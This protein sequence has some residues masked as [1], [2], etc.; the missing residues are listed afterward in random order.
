MIVVTGGAGFIG[1]NIVHAL[2][3]RGVTDMLIVDNL[4]SSYKFLNINALRYSD[5]MHKDEFL[6]VLK[7]ARSGITA[8]IHQGACSDT[9]QTDNEYLMRN[10]YLYSKEVL[11]ACN[12][13][14]IPLI[15]A[16]SAAV[17]G[18]AIAG[19]KED[20]MCEQPLNGY[21]F[22]KLAFDNHVRHRQAQGSLHTHVTGLR[23]FNVYGPQE[24]HKGHMAS[25]AFH[26]Y[27]QLKEGGAMKLFEGS[28]GFRRD[29]VHVDDA[30]AVVLH[31]LDR[32]ATGIFNCGTGR[33]EPFTAVAAQ[34]K[35]L[36][37]SSEVKQIPFPDHLKGKY[38]EYTCADV[39]NLRAAGCLHPFM[40]LAEGMARYFS[41]LQDSGGY[42][43][44]T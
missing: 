32:P 44:R 16:S 24:N 13:W 42:L 1:S 27:R 4:G 34:L 41:V 8:I 26:L 28:E 19:F 40:S 29:F 10:N 36:C 31:F 23:Y 37:P 3:R 11:N 20:H 43:T 17:Y 9:T 6:G 2:N 14:H 35:A 38:Q 7:G 39:H 15:Y 33:A 18:N 25:V 21:A 22:S 5:Y 30:V 12:R